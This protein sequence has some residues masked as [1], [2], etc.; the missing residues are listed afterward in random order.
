M[1]E[2][3]AYL[4][5]ED[6]PKRRSPIVATVPE[7]G[8]TAAALV[9]ELY[10][11]SA[12]T[13]RFLVKRGGLWAERERLHNPKARL[14]PGQRL[15][16]YLAPK[17]RYAETALRPE[18]ILYEDEWLIALNKPAAWYAQATP[19]DTA[20]TL[21]GAL[22]RYLTERD[23]RPPKLHFAQ[24]LD[25]GTAGVMLVAKHPKAAGPLAEALARP[26][27]RKIYEAWVQ[28]EPAWEAHE[29]A[30]G[31]GRGPGGV[32]QLYPAEQIGKRDIRAANTSFRALER[33]KTSALIAAEL[34]TGRT[35]QIRL[36]LQALGHPILGDTLYGGPAH[37]P[38][39]KLPHP[40]LCA[41]RLE[42]RHPRTGK[43]LHITA[44]PPPLWATLRG[45]LSAEPEASA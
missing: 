14:R 25:Q 20:G 41:I 7:T 9:A 6:L 39:L 2:D 28:G 37:L 1:N 36:H 5:L 43:P 31:H 44:P 29:S 10:S 32:W 33:H 35:H 22:N 4:T 45:L 24:R 8:G 16:L 3:N 11:V 26:D 19:W 15:E 38:G 13:A 21:E 40:L 30:T 34:H 18:H 23:R 12:E 42:L 27:T 17:G